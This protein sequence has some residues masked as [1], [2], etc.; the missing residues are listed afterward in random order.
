M[1]P[2]IWLLGLERNQ[3]PPSETMVRP[4][5]A[6]MAPVRYPSP[7]YGLRRTAS[8]VPKLRSGVMV[9]EGV[10]KLRTVRPPLRMERVVPA[11]AEMSAEVR[12]AK[13]EVLVER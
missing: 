1:G 3:W 5:R 12:R 13:M 10:S 6:V 2:A 11:G 7:K 9:V 4:L 8:A